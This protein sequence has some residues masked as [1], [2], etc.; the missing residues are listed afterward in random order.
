L[1]DTPGNNPD[2]ALAAEFPPAQHDVWLKLVDKILDGVPFDKKLVSRTYDGLSI[3]PLYT[4]DHWTSDGDPNGFPGAAP[5]VRGN[6]ALGT[7]D[8]WDLR[9]LHA[10][11]DPLVANKQILEDLERGVTSI[12]LKIDA[13]AQDGVCVRTVADLE[14]A[15]KGVLLDLAPVAL[16]PSPASLAN[17]AMLLE[18]LAAR[19]VKPDAF[20]GNF[21][22]DPIGVLAADGIAHGTASTM[23]APTADAAVHIAKAYPKARALNVSSLAYHG[24]GCAEAQELGFT[25]AAATEY[26]RALTAAGLTI[27]NACAQIALTVTADADQFVTIAKIR[28][29]RRLWARVAEA[30]GAATLTAPLT[31][32]TAPRMMSKRDPWVNILRTSIACFAAGVAGAEAVTVL[33]FDYAL[34]VP[35]SLGRRVARNTQIILQEESGLARVIDPAGG[36]W[37]FERLTDDIAN[38]AWRVFQKIESQSG[39]VKALAS[40]FVADEIAGVRAERAKNIARRKDPLTGVSEFPDINE[41]PV[42]GDK[43]NRDAIVKARAGATQRLDPLPAAGSGALMS[44]VR[45]AAK[46]GATSEAIDAAMPQDTLRLPALPRITLSQEFEKLRDAGDA[47]AA[48][49]GARPKIFL[50][51][52]GTIAEFTARASFAKNFFEAGGIAAVSGT[53]G[54]DTASIAEDFRRTN[55]AL[56]VICGTDKL[57]AAHGVELAKALRS[58]GAAVMYLAGRGGDLEAALKDAGVNGF[59]FMGCDVTAL[60]KDVHSKLEAA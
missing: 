5:F 30:S 47:Y 20:T 49:M 41:T 28:A 12:A 44:A 3:H 52:L 22:F 51:C 7:R 40:G 27:D 4:Q 36:A 15:L 9:Q 33:P 45:A 42:E 24:A 16:E 25:L 32:R 26:L 17:A 8:G 60:L 35:Q 14:T 2:L 39:M 23:L 48:K 53:G 55:A 57:Y 13:S 38:A 29:M 11:P 6:T 10:H 34:G 37:L 58:A 50:A 31:A 59:I 46:S 56:A 43:V 18:V 19:G 21:G 1:P 54:T